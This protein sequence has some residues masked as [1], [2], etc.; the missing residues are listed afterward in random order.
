MN[1]VIVKICQRQTTVFD[2]VVPL[3]PLTLMSGLG[4]VVLL[5]VQCPIGRRHQ[6]YMR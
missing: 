1:E 3:V 2:F 5:R 6:L 4:M